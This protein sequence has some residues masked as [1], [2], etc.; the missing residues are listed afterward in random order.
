MWAK[1]MLAHLLDGRFRGTSN[2]TLYFGQPNMKTMTASLALLWTLAAV[3]AGG[4]PETATSLLP[5]ETASAAPKEPAPGAP[6]N[7]RIIK[8]GDL[9]ENDFPSGPNAGESTIDW[10]SGEALLESTGIH[11]YYVQLASRPDCVAAYSLRD[12]NQVAEYRGS[13]AKPAAVTYVW[14]NDPDPR[15]QDAAKIVIPDGND[16]LPTQVWLPLNHAVRTP[17]L[18]TWDVWFGKEWHFDHAGIATYKTWQF[19][20]PGSTINTEVRSRFGLAKGNPNVVAYTDIRKYGESKGGVGP[21]IVPGPELG[22]HNYGSQA[23]GPMSNEFGIAPERWARFW[24]LL[25]PDGDWYRLSLWGA[26]TE[27]DAVQIYSGLQVKPNIKLETGG[28]ASMD[29]TWG[30]FRLEYNTSANAWW[31]GRGPLTAYFRNFVVLRA[32]SVAGLLQ[33][34]VP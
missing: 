12:Q 15:R 8:G 32:S 17:L 28:T 5:C 21:N 33:R 19:G 30:I 13:K 34:P 27:R 2:P 29:G 23:V 16:S 31:E 3:S 18:A 10:P 25:V 14:P 24:L 11:D 6:K 20:S 7:L 22:G 1:N 4:A 9:E 26:D